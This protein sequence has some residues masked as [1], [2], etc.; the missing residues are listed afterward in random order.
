MRLMILGAT[1]AVGSQALGQALAE[2][3]IEQVIAPTRRALTL[4]P[5]LLN[6]IVEFDRLPEEEAWWGVDAVV[7]ALGST[8][9]Q[10]GSV[11]RLR[12]IDL[13]YVIAAAR[14]AKKAGCTT[15]VYNSSISA[16]PKSLS[17]YL[18]IKAE[19]EKSLEALQFHSLTLVRPSI[20]DAG[21]RP[22]FRLM[23]SLSLKLCRL[24]EPL[25]PKRWRPVKTSAVAACLLHAAMN[26]EAGV[27]VVESE[28]L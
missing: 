15:F 13:D 2:P 19:V 16:S 4:H 7:C 1:G 10:A 20:L 17:Y 9:K 18:K 25:M 12:Q 21:E 5:K 23:E 26:R 22:D 24:I 27:R 3:A 6:P 8:I 11:K 28:A 14:L